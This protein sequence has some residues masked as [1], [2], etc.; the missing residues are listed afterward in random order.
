MRI[1]AAELERR[2]KQ[3]EAVYEEASAAAAAAV[4]CGPPMSRSRPCWSCLVGSEY[5]GAYSAPRA[6]A[7]ARRGCLF[8]Q[9][10]V[11]RRPGDRSTLDEREKAFH[12]A[13][14]WVADEV[15]RRNCAREFWWQAHGCCGREEGDGYAAAVDRGAARALANTVGRCQSTNPLAPPSRPL[16]GRPAQVASSSTGDV[17]DTGTG[18]GHS[19][20][21]IIVADLKPEAL[22]QL[23][24]S[25]EGEEGAAGICR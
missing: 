4:A 14:Q 10:I 6:L 5:C 23:A 11:H 21:R 3:K 13:R 8:A 7:A 9:D 24:G 15:G 25:D 2:Y 16:P 18:G 1:T 20:T 22:Q 12:A 19:F 17:E